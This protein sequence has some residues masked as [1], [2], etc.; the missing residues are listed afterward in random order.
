MNPYVDYDFYANEFGGTSVSAEQFDSY[1]RK[2]RMIIDKHTF[3]R[4]KNAIDNKDDFVVPEEIKMAQCAVIDL[5]YKFDMAGGVVVSSE[6]VSK[7]SQTYVGVK[8]VDQ[9]IYETVRLY[10]GGTPWTY[11][12]G[13]KG[14]VD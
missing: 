4:V 1:E 7:H 9:S 12:G 2:S 13:G 5:L 3:N 11:F 14:Y 8:T 6:T 10:L